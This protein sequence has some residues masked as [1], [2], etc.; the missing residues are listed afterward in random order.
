MTASKKSEARWWQRVTRKGAWTCPGPLFALVCWAG[1][2]TA[3]RASLD[4]CADTCILCARVC[5]V[6]GQLHRQ[7]G[8]TRAYIVVPTNLPCVCHVLQCQHVSCA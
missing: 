5:V 4:A 3:D 8:E 1:V 2:H 6:E 7:G